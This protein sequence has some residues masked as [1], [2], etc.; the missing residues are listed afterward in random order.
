[1]PWSYALVVLKVVHESQPIPNRE[2]VRQ[3]PIL[4]KRTIPIINERY[5]SLESKEQRN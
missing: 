1:M 4:I 3:F 2:K 5:N